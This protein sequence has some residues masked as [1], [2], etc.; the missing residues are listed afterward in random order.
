MVPTLAAT[1]KSGVEVTVFPY[2]STSVQEGSDGRLPA[3]RTVEVK[4]VPTE[5][6][7]IGNHSSMEPQ[8]GGPTCPLAVGSSSRPSNVALKILRLYKGE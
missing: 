5:A 1:V 2:P 4:G 7:L 3:A 8:V 6:P